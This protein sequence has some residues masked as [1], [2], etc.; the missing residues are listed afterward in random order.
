MAE[1]PNKDRI[2]L[3]DPTLPEVLREAGYSTALIG[4]W[5]IGPR[6]ELVGFEQAI[7]PRIPH[8]Y[9]GQTYYQI[10]HDPFSYQVDEFG[11]DWEIGRV[12]EFLKSQKCGESLGSP[13]FLS[14]NISLPH[15]PIGPGNLPDRYA[16][17]Y[18]RETVP[19]RQNAIIDGVPAYS[20]FWFKTYT[21]WDY[22]FRCR[23]TDQ[24]DR[25]T[26]IL[27]SG[28]DLRDLTAY[29]YGGVS[30]V[31]ACVGRLLIRPGRRVSD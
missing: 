6:P 19:I 26:D 9:F 4:K 17:M 10:G 29:Y 27:P 30:C 28:F 3:L 2:R 8:R 21:I 25:P 23:G 1:P 15:M 7:Y 11:P 18:D 12:E 24:S 16:S 13:F 20:D 14:Y 5:H 31:D 22:F